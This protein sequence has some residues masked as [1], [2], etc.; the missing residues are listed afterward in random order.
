MAEC[1]VCQGIGAAPGANWEAQ[2]QFVGTERRSPRYVRSTWR[3]AACGAH[4]ARL[5]VKSTGQSSWTF[6]GRPDDV[7]A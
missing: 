6:L 4:W 7:A 2:L 1:I 5:Q 3:C